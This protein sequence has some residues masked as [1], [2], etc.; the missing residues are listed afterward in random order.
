MSNPKKRAAEDAPPSVK[1]SKKRKS[2]FSEEGLDEQLG[3]NTL[4][5]RM[6]NQL[7]AD[8]LAQKMTRFGTDLSPVE[9]SDLSLSGKTHLTRRHDGLELT[10]GSQRGSRH[11]FVAGEPDAG[12]APRFPGKILG[13]PGEP[14]EG[15]EE[16]GR[17][18][19]PHRR[20]SWS[21]S[22]GHCQVQ[23]DTVQETRSH[24]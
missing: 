15:A 8:H 24:G 3:V 1:K 9:L 22:G 13:K 16:E 11:H 5:A 10:E 2:K 6:D 14:D 17:T 23:A 7:L 18:A 20:R 19:H 21:T 12:Q 4:F